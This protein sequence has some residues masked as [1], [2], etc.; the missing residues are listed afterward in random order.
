MSD[1]SE[2]TKD[3]NAQISIE[4]QKV[5]ED[6]KKIKQQINQIQTQLEL[7][8]KNLVSS[9]FSIFALEDAEETKNEMS[10]MKREL[11]KKRKTR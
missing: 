7:K 11:T 1:L 5:K 10:K 4:R 8:A 9:H 2:R 6:N 3:M